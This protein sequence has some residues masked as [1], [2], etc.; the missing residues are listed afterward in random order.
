MDD[1][2]TDVAPETTDVVADQSQV[3]EPSAAV[4]TETFTDLDPNES[5]EGGHTPEWLSERH[6]QMQ[7]DY[8]RKT[9]AHAE[10]VKQHQ[11]GIDF[12]EALRSDPDTQLA[13]MQQ[14]SELL[15]ESG[16]DEGEF[17]STEE[18]DPLQARIEQLEQ[19]RASERAQALGKEIH[20]HIEQLAK[21]AGLDLDEEEF[22]SIF[23][24]AT[25][26]DTIDRT[27]TEAAFK[28]FQEKQKQ[29][30]DKWQKSYL[31]SKQASAQVPAGTT[32]T[33]KP[34]LND[35]DTRLNRFAAILRGE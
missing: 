25:G 22:R 2:S 4:E 35:R 9:Q 30:Y 23:G 3:D 5:P 34:D 17:E 6:K 33:D 8:T 18:A 32:A 31:A 10:A 14:L 13:V 19:E 29:Q 15:G 7:A 16:D 27:S 26:G 21:D 12:L 11:E 24:K 1:L 20:S 28:T